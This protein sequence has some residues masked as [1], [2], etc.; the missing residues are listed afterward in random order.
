MT[1]LNTKFWAS[2]SFT[3]VMK[4]STPTPMSKNMVTDWRMLKQFLVPEVITELRMYLLS[5]EEKGSVSWV[6]GKTA[7]LVNALILKFGKYVAVMYNK[8]W[9]IGCIRLCEDADVLVKFMVEKDD[10]ELVHSWPQTENRCHIPFHRV[11]CEYQFHQFIAIVDER[12]KFIPSI[13]QL[14]NKKFIHFKT[15]EMRI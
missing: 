4:R 7:I 12:Y 2:L 13:I 6:T 15:D 10:S 5:R 11:L 1:G 14:V 3:K 8:Q 9:Y